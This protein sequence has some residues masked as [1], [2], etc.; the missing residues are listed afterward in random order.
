MGRWWRLRREVCQVT[1]ACLEVE[2]RCVLTRARVPAWCAKNFKVHSI[3]TKESREDGKF[4][5][6]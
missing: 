6:G 5:I 4:Q 2:L 1:G 3:Q